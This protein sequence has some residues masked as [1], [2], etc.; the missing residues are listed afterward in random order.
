MVGIYKITN[1][2][3]N[4]AYIGQ[5]VNI[6]ERWR[7][8]KKDYNRIDCSLYRAFRKYG[9]ENFKFEILEEL[10]FD[11]T[12]MYERETFYVTLLNTLKNGYND[13]LPELSVGILNR[14]FTR[15]EVINI[16]ERKFLG[17]SCHEVYKD[18]VD[19]I[20]ELGFIGGVWNGKTYTDVAMEGYTKENLSKL[21]SQNLQGEKNPKAKLTESDV[22]DIRTRKKRGEA[23][24]FVFC[25]YK[26][27]ISY[28][29][30]RQV[31]GGQSWKH[32]VLS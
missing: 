29:G 13:I 5:S 20:T 11:R 7:Q 15:E 30:M 19:R 24:R 16:R 12:K 21:H 28:G 8:H 17:E 25:D 27:R 10:E 26:E 9:I 14:V 2:T 18:Y 22:I 4:K 32:V 3:N 23:F 1:K 6:E 31:W